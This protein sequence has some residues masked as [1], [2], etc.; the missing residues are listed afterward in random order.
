MIRGARRALVVAHPDD[1]VLWFAGVLIRH[2]GDWTIICCSIPR[3]DPERGWRF[4]NACDVLGAKGRVLPYVEADPN[5]DLQHLKLL[6][7]NLAGFDEVFSHNAI[8][9]YGHHHHRC[10][11]RHVAAAA[12][13]RLWV[14][15]YGLE[16]TDWKLHLTDREWER[17]L[18]AL[19]RYDHTSPS[20]GIPKSEALLA[21]YGRQFDLKSESYARYRA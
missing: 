19:R 9:E 4:F 18:E 5:S 21:R 10:V 3:T 8:G 14:S 17:K 15:G 2:P 13:D 1:E 16:A 6:N 20:D 7:Y 12:G 11:H